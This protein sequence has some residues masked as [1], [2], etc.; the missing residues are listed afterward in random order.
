MLTSPR[1]LSL[2]NAVGGIESPAIIRDPDLRLVTDLEEPHIRVAGFGVRDDVTQCFLRDSVDAECSVRR[3]SSKISLRSAR[4]RDAVGTL[5]LATV[6]SQAPHQPQMLQHGRMQ[7]VRELANVACE[8]ERL[9]LKLHQFLLQLL[10]DVILAQ[11][12][13]ETTEGDRYAR[14]LLTDVVVQV[15]RDPCP[16]D[17]LRL[18]QAA[19]QILN[20]LMACFQ[21]S[22]AR[23]NPIFGVFPSP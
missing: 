8:A 21:R 5:E 13:L 18:D 15:P 7:I 2:L 23:A 12:L 20:L 22:L 11:P 19:G 14:Q 17:L 10:T 1:P 16:L 3:D 4:H 9:L 6:R